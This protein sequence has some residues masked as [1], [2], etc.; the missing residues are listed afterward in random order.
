[1]IGEVPIAQFAGSYSVG[2]YV[3]AKSPAG[4]RRLARV[5][6]PISKREPRGRRELWLVKMRNSL[7]WTSPE[8]LPVEKALLPGDLA[9]QRRLGFI[10]ERGEPS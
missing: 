9:L 5:I 1:V 2:D 10:D 7:R 3:Y 8:W 4:Y 6:S